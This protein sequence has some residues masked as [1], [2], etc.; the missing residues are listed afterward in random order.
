MPKRD[1]IGE[2]RR[3]NEL[4]VLARAGVDL[5]DGGN[6]NMEDKENGVMKT[7]PSHTT[8]PEEED[9]EALE[10]EDEFYKQVKRQRTGKLTEKAQLYSRFVL[11]TNHLNYSITS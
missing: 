4:R 10:S 2:R 8:G 7:K 6:S 5:E 1:D 3:R 11:I 9:D